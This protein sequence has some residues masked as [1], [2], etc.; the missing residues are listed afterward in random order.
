MFRLAV[1]QVS[2]RRSD[3]ASG[4][5]VGVEERARVHEQSDDKAVETCRR[6]S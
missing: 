2:I 6:D 4:S 1:A 5:A 3:D